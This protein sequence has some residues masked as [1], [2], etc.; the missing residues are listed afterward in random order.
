MKIQRFTVARRKGRSGGVGGSGDDR[1]SRCSAVLT[2]TFV[3]ILAWLGFLVYCWYSGRLLQTAKVPA[4]ASPAVDHSLRGAT[5]DLASAAGKALAQGSSGLATTL[6]VA[7]VLVGAAKTV[8][9]VIPS[10]PKAPA[11]T[12]KPADIHIIFSTDCTVG[13]PSHSQPLLRSPFP[14]CLP[15]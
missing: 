12:K 5:H 2:L 9:A 4:P 11:P 7:N 3:V 13:L 1:S 14:A 10:I 15:C 8:A 6:P